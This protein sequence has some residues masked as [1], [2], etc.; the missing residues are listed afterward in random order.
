MATPKRPAQKTTGPQA[1]D[2]SELW[3]RAMQDTARISPGRRRV[4]GVPEETQ[5][6][7]PPP[8]TPSRQGRAPTN[9]GA[10]REPKPP[11]SAAPG[12]LDKHV[13]RRIR[14]GAQRIEARLDLHGM[15]QKEAHADL[16]RFIRDTAARG[17]RC[18]LVITGK[19][20]RATREDTSREDSFDR[21]PPGV[22]RRSV[23]HWL[24][25]PDLAPLVA[26]YEPALPQHGGGGALYVQLR[27]RDGK[28]GG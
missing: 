6:E 2:D 26:G 28:G 9:Q 14:R 12:K 13:V 3:Q 25:A 22:L 21:S 15:T 24:S 23:P 16:R 4:L 7:G 17:C 18:V 1:E 19:G 5:G 27:R 20:S 10:R 11:A 8:A